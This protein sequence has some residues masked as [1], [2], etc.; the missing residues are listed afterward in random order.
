MASFYAELHVGGVSYRV[1][2]CNY[3]FRQATTARGRVQAKVRHLPLE[4]T[5]DVP[6]DD[7]LLAWAHAPH[8]PL[9]GAVVF[10]DM[11]AQVAHETIAFAAG[12]CVRYAEQFASGATGN[13]AY[14]CQLTIAA[15]SFEL[16]AGGP[17]AVEASTMDAAIGGAS[18]AE[19]LPSAAL[20]VGSG[21][22]IGAAA[23]AGGQALAITNLLAATK[24]VNPTNSQTNCADIAT[25]LIA[26][27]RGT[28]PEAVAGD[29][30]VQFI[31]DIE[32]THNVKFD[33]GQD[34]HQAFNTIRNS[35][36]GTIGL[37]VMVPKVPGM[38]HVVTIVNQ[39]GVPTILEGQ[40]WD[41]FNPAEVITSSSRAE[42]RYGNPDKVHLG[43][44]IVS[45]PT[46][47]LA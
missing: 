3:E 9:A 37:L 18:M 33:F 29:T 24:D 10:Y 2:H 30:P 38:G 12:E 26:R 44:A 32:A 19:A 42:R 36:E 20:A 6:T 15:P 31:P 7:Q 16:R 4:L 14:V 11:A 13:G 45:P 39:E 22:D 34:F 28:N 43:L 5:L 41:P 17:A 23:K 46:E 40:R 1:L 21:E 25:A 8:K 47:P 27:L 35:P